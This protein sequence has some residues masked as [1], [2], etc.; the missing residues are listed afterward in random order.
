MTSSQ[1]KAQIKK[2]NTLII[3]GAVIILSLCL[4]F[5][6]TLTFIQSSTKEIIKAQIEPSIEFQTE[7][8]GKLAT[9]RDVLNM[10]EEFPPPD[11]VRLKRIDDEIRGNYNKFPSQEEMIEQLEAYD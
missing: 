1:Q 5:F 6:I 3:L 8:L 7:T 9:I 10:C 2:L 11:P 4:S